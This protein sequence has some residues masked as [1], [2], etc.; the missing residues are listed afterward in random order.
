MATAG[1]K[2]IG[3]LIS[4]RLEEPLLAADTILIRD[5]LIAAVGRGDILEDVELN[6]LVDAHGAG[7]LPGLIDS[8]VHP[9]A[10]D[11]TPRQSTLNFID[12]SL[13]G[14]VTSMIS[15]G[16]VHFPG[17]PKDA[18]GVKALATLAHAS[19]HNAR[20]SGVKV[21]GGA[22]ILEPGLTEADFEE[23]QRAG[24][25]LVGEIGLGQVS[26]PSEA[27]PMVEWAHRHDFTVLMHCGGTSIPGSSVVTADHVAEVEPDVV[28]HINGGPT[29]TSDTDIRRIIAEM[30]HAVE[31]V[32]CGNYRAAL[33]ALDEIRN[34]AQFDRLILGND[35]PSGTGVI[36]LGILRNLAFVA[37]VG[38]LAPAEAVACATGN[39]ARVFGLN[40]G[41]IEP[42]READIVI[43]DAP[44]GS[45]GATVLEAL[46][47]GD[48]PGISMVLI[49]GDVRV[50]KS[51]HTPP[52]VRKATIVDAP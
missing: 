25:W 41:V 34:C 37:S 48:L 33:V 29:A 14:G 38:G 49:D 31:I 18:V 22:L 7:V 39:S 6:M 9:T 45:A 30:P 15:A 42:G 13:H 20:P 16:E 11:F 35:A 26:D 4:G 46:Q 40:T 8:H 27:R 2:N 32:Q 50:T 47:V 44:L 10:G 28:C 21:H 43:A 5:G 36:P 51:R 17:R 23:L 12:S 19:F 3:Q 24:V 52:P 1:I